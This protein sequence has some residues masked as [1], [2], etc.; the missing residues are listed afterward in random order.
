MS[1]KHRR[2]TPQWEWEQALI[3]AYYDRRWHE[4]LDPLYE[5]FQR[6]KA[7]EL[8]HDDMDKAIHETLK[9]RRSIWNYFTEK[10]TDVVDWIQF[11]RDWF[12]PWLAAHP[13]PAGIELVPAPRRPAPNDREPEDTEEGA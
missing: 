11:D 2:G 3:D 1:K 9:P 10:R 12:E 5:Q 8:H 6:W 7:G 4:V 13:P